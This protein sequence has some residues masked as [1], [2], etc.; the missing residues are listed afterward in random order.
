MLELP[1]VQRVFWGNALKDMV[2]MSKADLLLASGSTFSLWA[3]F[4]GRLDAIAYPGQL[5]EKIA[6]DGEN[7][8]ERECL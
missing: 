3:R 4:L 6:L 1:N 7:I 5:R 8:M 2:A